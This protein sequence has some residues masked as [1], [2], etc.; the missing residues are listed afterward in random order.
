MARTSTITEY[1]EGTVLVDLVDPDNNQL[2]WRGSGVAMV[3]DNPSKYLATCPVSSQDRGPSAGSRPGCDRL[4]ERRPAIAVTAV[5]VDGEPRACRHGNPVS[6][7]ISSQPGRSMLRAAQ[8]IEAG[9]AV[10]RE[11]PPHPDHHPT[12]TLA[13]SAIRPAADMANWAGHPRE[14]TERTAFA[15][16]WAVGK[17]TDSRTRTTTE[18][19]VRTL[20]KPG[21]RRETR[22]I[23]V[24]PATLMG[25]IA[26]CA[27]CSRIAGTAPRD[28]AAQ[29][30]YG[31]GHEPR[32]PKG[33]AAYYAD[34]AVVR[35]AR[36]V[37]AQGRGEI[38]RYFA[39]IGKATWK[40]DVIQVGG[41]AQAP[42]QVGRS[43][44]IHG[45][46]PDTCSRVFRRVLEA[47]AGWE[48][49]NPARLL[50]LIR[51]H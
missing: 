6:V 5:R 16:R 36:S 24:F 35:T 49:E 45:T 31:S 9:L 48:T 12:F 29:P 51:Y 39:D 28:R 37:V 33:A 14:L 27:A 38:D 42:Y 47:P 23:P 44:L 20:S 26:V 50:P 30:R 13:S 40:L 18:K 3:S 21:G 25:N 43:T 10:G 32:R 11:P 2:V 17:Q 34:D 41:D 1:T 22:T 7:P 4:N 19:Q 15:V 46:R 8:G